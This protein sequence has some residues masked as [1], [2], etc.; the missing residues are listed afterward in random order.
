MTIAVARLSSYLVIIEFCTG[1]R[2]AHQCPM[3][4]PSFLNIYR[5]HHFWFDSIFLFLFILLRVLFFLW[6]FLLLLSF[7]PD[8]WKTGDKK[9]P[10]FSYLFRQSSFVSDAGVCQPVQTID[11]KIRF[12]QGSPGGLELFVFLIGQNVVVDVVV[13]NGLATGALNSSNPGIDK[14]SLSL[15]LSRSLSSQFVLDGESTISCSDRM[16][17]KSGTHGGFAVRAVPFP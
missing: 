11:G 17:W 7:V 16:E 14:R 2:W 13:V 3:M 4:P 8:W 5:R 1:E 6:T 9:A 12:F 10:W 15:A